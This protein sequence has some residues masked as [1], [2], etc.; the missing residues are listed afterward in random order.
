MKVRLAVPAKKI[1]MGLLL[2][3]TP[4]IG[5][6]AGG[7]VSEA[8][9]NLPSGDINAGEQKVQLCSACHGKNGV[10]GQSLYPN[11][12]GQGEKYLLKQLLDIKSNK[13][14]IVEMSGLLDGSSEQD[15][16]DMAAYYAAQDTAISGAKEIGNDDYGLT[17]KEMLALGE[18]L[19]RGGN[20]SQNIPAC[21]ACHSPRGLGNAPA[22][23]PAIGGQH[24]D[25]I[26]KQL[27]MFRNNQRTNDGESRIMRGAV[28]RMSNLEIQALSNYIAGLH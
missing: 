21:A 6:S 19:Y 4:I 5:F 23:Y 8:P 24:A 28:E 3:C 2:V 16:R 7:G 13:R 1:V 17:A 26:A 10:S 12:A 9:E 25:Y 27:D 20:L 14:N 15:L 18:K 11:L 22:G